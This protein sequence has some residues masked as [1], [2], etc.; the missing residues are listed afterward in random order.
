MADNVKRSWPRWV[1]SIGMLTRTNSLVRS[2]CYECG[3]QLR[4]DPAQLAA[5][6]GLAASL[7]DRSDR[8]RMVACHGHV[9]YMAAWSYG[10]AW[11]LLAERADLLAKTKDAVPAVNAQT[12]HRKSGQHTGG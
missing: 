7:I 3:V 8:C 1:Q 9:F 4:E 2:Q 6:L 12:L 5:T 11:I 10:R